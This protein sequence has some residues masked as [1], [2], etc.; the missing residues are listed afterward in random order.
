VQ[1][2]ARGGEL[3]GTLS[4][5]ARWLLKSTKTSATLFTLFSTTCTSPPQP[6][7]QKLCSRFAR[8]LMEPARV[9]FF[10]SFHLLKPIR[11]MARAQSRSVQI[12]QKWRRKQTSLAVQDVVIGNRTLRDRSPK[13]SPFKTPITTSRVAFLNA[14]VKTQKV[15]FGFALK[16]RLFEA[17]VLFFG[18]VVTK[19]TYFHRRGRYSSRA[20]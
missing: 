19:I 16:S 4:L 8:C 17:K 12:E 14:R 1:L 9:S 15:L 20:L 6:Y 11:D 13:R 7:D 18:T 3:H 5:Y 10:A 2:S